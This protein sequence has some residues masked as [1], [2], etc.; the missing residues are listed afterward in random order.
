MIVI[1]VIRR[2]FSNVRAPTATTTRTTTLHHSSLVVLFLCTATVFRALA[3]H[4]Q[5]N[6]S[7]ASSQINQRL[8]VGWLPSLI[9]STPPCLCI[10][11]I[12]NKVHTLRPLQLAATHTSTMP[13]L[14]T[15]RG[16]SRMLP[17]HHS[18]TYHMISGPLATCIKSS[19]ICKVHYQHRVLA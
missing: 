9:R 12:C 1:M 15:F 8:L 3:L 18:P 6:L 10:N 13:A 4:G 16:M 2:R 7:R 14:P 5:H 11:D 19:L 17:I